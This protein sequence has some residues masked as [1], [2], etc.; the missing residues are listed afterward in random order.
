M[1]SQK[2]TARNYKI[3]KQKHTELGKKRSKT[4][5]HIELKNEN[6]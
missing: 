1:L 3:F 5:T 6:L 4:N 2:F